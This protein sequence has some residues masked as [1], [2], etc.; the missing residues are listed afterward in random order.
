M[1][2]VVVSGATKGIG[3]A[4]ADHFLKGGANVAICA[5]SEDDLKEFQE[6]VA[7]NYPDQ[8]VLIKVA[9]VSKKADVTAFADHVK[10]NW[11]KVD[12]LV[13]NAGVFFPGEVTKED[14][15]VLE[16]MINT[17][18]Y[19]AYHLTRALLP[20]IKKSEKGYIFNISSIAGLQAY[21]NGGSYSI[22]KFAMLGLS[23][24]LR[25]E[26][27]EDGIGVC[28]VLPG[29]TLT[30]AWDGVDL[31]ESRFIDVQDIGKL[32][33]DIYN[34]SH[35]TVIEDIVIRPMLGDI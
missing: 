11:P 30:S 8:Q 17:N 6:L 16:Q 13:N 18:L 19:S 9:D 10:Q 32:V 14:D 7:K 25:E 15:G 34:F 35:R 1:S 23:K 28:S 12:V 2:Y 22:S 5:R 3:R 26:L 20:S 21:N 29:A 33:C 24:A 27:K 4:I 31:P